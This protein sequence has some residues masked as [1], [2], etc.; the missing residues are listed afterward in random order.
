MSFVEGIPKKGGEI[1]RTGG[2]EFRINSFFFSSPSF[3]RLSC[4]LQDFPALHQT[5]KT[6]RNEI[7]V[8]ADKSL[9]CQS[10]PRVGALFI[11]MR[12]RSTNASLHV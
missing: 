6:Q 4:R 12:E 7:E 9:C 11:E 3:K 2:W 1:G 8:R 10:K 5:E